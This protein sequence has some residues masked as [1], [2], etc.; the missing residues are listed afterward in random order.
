MLLTHPSYFIVLLLGVMLLGFNISQFWVSLNDV[1]V[2][3]VN[4]TI[5]W[6]AFILVYLFFG[7]TAV[8]NEKNK[9][10]NK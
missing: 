4:V 8:E 6:L 3:A 1:L 2:T 10:K 5:F 9:S 7:R